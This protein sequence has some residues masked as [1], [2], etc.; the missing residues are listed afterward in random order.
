MQSVDHG[1]F[2]S[3]NRIMRAKGKQNVIMLALKILL[4]IMCFLWITFILTNSL[5]TAG[6]SSAQSETVVET[7]QRV[8]KAIAPES[9]IANATGETYDKLHLLV[10]ACAHVMEFA[11]LGVLLGWCYFA[12]T[13]KWKLYFI[14]CLG[15]LLIAAVDEWIQTFVEGRAWEMTDLLLDSFGGVT[16]VLFAALSVVLGLLIYEKR[17]L[18]KAEK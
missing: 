15:V 6:E 3:Y 13:L 11:V 1:Y 5:Q 8:A 12:Y 7:V 17:L 9:T 4:P 2:F 10:R 16:G 14:P 18:K